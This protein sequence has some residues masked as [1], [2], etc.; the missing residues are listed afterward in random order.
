MM[1]G[2]VMA[3]SARPVREVM[4]PRTEIVA[5]EEN[6]PLEEIRLVFAGSGYSRIPVIRGTLDDIIGMLHAFDLFKLEPGDPLPVRPV[7]VTPASR[8]LR[9]SS[10]RHAA[11]A[12]PSRRWCWMSSAAPSASLPWKICWRSWWER[13]STSTMRRSVRSPA[14]V[15]SSVR[16]GWERL[17]SGHRG[18]VRRIPA[19]G[20]LHH[21]RRSPGRVGRPDPQRRRT[22]RRARSRVRCGAGLTHPDRTPADPVRTHG[23]GSAAARLLMIKLSR[24]HGRAGPQ[25][26]DRALHPASA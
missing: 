9:R 26:R 21:S 6:A 3:F 19:P 8:Q 11:G 23:R 14:A 22:V 18:A 25:G 4:T 24:P 15:A 17:D 20:A 2:G 10:A 7:A 1:V 13:S 12:A 5:I 16:D